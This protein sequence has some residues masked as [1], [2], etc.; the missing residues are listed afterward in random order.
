MTKS[1]TDAF[2]GTAWYYARYRSGYPSEFFELAKQKFNLTKIDRVL[3]LGC[4][5]GQ[6][7][8]PIANY[9]R[10]VIAMDPEPEMLAEGKQQAQKAYTSNIVWIEGGS[11]DIEDLKD[12]LGK[13]KLT[14][15]GS[16]FHW[17]NREKTLDKLY[18]LTLDNGGI[19]IVGS[20]SV[21][22]KANEWQATIKSVIQ[23]WV[24]E[25]R[26]AGSGTYRVPA[27]KYEDYLARSKFHRVETWR[28]PFS[29]TDHLESV[30]GNIYSTSFAN[31]NVLKNNKEAFESELKEALLKQNPS[32]EFVSEGI[33]EA[34]LAWKLGN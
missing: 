15:M 25:E 24:G 20:S 30:V 5:T 12:K 16:S 19:I 4:G 2:K 26:R 33:V 29:V 31:I 9:V 17:M 7:A 23:K 11:E 28:Y 14:T 22:T 34:F 6:I 13:F 21:W 10:E 18:E 32:G 8:I 1:Y 27:K 3:D